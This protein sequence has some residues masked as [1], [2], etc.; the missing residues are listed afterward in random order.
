MEEEYTER[1]NRW[2]GAGRIKKNTLKIR[3][4]T[5]TQIRSTSQKLKP[6]KSYAQPS[7]LDCLYA[8]G[9]ITRRIA[10]SLSFRE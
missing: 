3:K 10:S 4:T 9:T 8:E 6:N 5:K 7:E 2:A 1:K